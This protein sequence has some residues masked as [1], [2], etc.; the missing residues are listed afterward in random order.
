MADTKKVFIVDDDKFLLDMYSIKFKEGGFDVEVG[1]GGEEGLQK[2][3]SGLVVDVIMLDIVMPSVDGFAF[4]EAIRRE[5]LGGDP[6]IVVLSN[7]GQQ[8]E[9][10]RAMQL[11]ADDYI[12][13][14]SA[15][16]SEVL[17]QIKKIVGIEE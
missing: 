7:Q 16:P 8:E 15:I 2:L 4:L 1:A 17:A 12:V 11:G 13:K 10:D 14:A 5:K 6:K 9:I 3:R